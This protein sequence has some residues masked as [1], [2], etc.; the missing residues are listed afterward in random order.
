M[1][2]KYRISVDRRYI[3]TVEIDDPL[4]QDPRSEAYRL[5]LI[6]RDEVY[7]ASASEVTDEPET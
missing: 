3:A 2:I 4:V 5:G 6:Q 1:G 7:R